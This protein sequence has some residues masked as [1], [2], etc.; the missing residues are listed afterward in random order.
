MATASKKPDTVIHTVVA[1]G[2]CISNNRSSEET[3]CGFWAGSVADSFH[4]PT[5]SR[6]S[7]NCV[8]GRHEHVPSHGICSCL[9]N[10]L[11]SADYRS[12]AGALVCLGCW[13]ACRF[14]IEFNAAIT[15][16]FVDDGKV[17]QSKG[18]FL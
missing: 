13:S 16:G 17:S 12:V 6:S 4:I 7:C 11:G 3:C 2:F 10:G 15:D 18:F 14:F 8:V 1:S 5:S 9:R